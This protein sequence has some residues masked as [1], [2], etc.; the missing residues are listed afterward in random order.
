MF[1]RSSF[2]QCRSGFLEMDLATRVRYHDTMHGAGVLQF[3]GA[4]E[5]L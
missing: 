2:S 1:K 3:S 4:L 5:W